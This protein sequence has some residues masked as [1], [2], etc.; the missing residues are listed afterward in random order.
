MT[1]SRTVRGP[2]CLAP[3]REPSAFRR[4]RGAEAWTPARPG[5]RCARR[6][7]PALAPSSTRLVRSSRLTSSSPRVAERDR[8]D[9]LPLHPAPLQPV[10][11]GRATCWLEA[12]GFSLRRS[13]RP[14]SRPPG[15]SP[16]WTERRRTPWRRSANQTSARWSAVIPVAAGQPIAVA[17]THQA[18][19]GNRPKSRWRPPWSGGECRNPGCRCNRTL[20]RR[21]YFASMTSPPSAFPAAALGSRRRCVLERAVAILGRF[22]R[23]SLD[24]GR[25]HACPL[26]PSH[27]RGRRGSRRRSRRWPTWPA[28]D[29]ALRAVLPMAMSAAMAVTSGPPHRGRRS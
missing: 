28:F 6:S 11:H 7:S 2:R 19:Y 5:R 17:A 29:G 8:P 23:S 27:W 25:L 3:G 1:I 13:A 4:G 9:W 12:V 18:S 10:P 21:C 26:G 16:S 22:L 20:P 15:S 24:A 14:G